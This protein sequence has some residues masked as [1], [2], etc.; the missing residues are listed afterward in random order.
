MQPVSCEA[1]SVVLEEGVGWGVVTSV[2]VILSN[3]YP[4]PSIGF[5]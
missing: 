2:D 1:T 3:I 5:L 4:I